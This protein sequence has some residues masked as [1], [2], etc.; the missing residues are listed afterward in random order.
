M[1]TNIF[2]E[3]IEK[4]LPA[5]IIYETDKI[6]AIK[7]KYPQAP[8]HLLI[9]P[10]KTYKDLQSLPKDEMGILADIVIC[11]QELAAKYNVVNDYRL[12]TNNGREAG[13][14]IFHLHFHLIGGRRL[15]PMA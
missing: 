8:V 5:E 14:T 6:I 7:D 3:I 11:A 15:G 9:M 1:T 13:Q 2:A 10:K 4:K 12:L